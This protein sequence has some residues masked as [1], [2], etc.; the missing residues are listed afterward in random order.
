MLHEL[1]TNCVKYGALSVPEG[2]VTIN[3]VVRDRVLKLQWVERGGPEVI[4]P[5][6]RGFGTILIEQ[7]SN[8][9]GGSAQMLCEA[10]GVT[11]EVALPLPQ[12]I[13][14][15]A[16][17]DDFASKIVQAE[18]HKDSRTTR[19]SGS[20]LSGRSF[21]VI[22]DEPLIALDLAGSL[23]R[24]GAASVRSV[25]NEGEALEMIERT[26]FEGAL[27]DANLHGRSVDAIAAALARRKIPFVFVT[28]YGREALPS[29][30][31]HVTTLGK[32]F[33]HQQLLD[34]IKEVIPGG[35]VVRL[36]S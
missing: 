31:R 2:W 23:E 15:R 3:W 36:K 24:A 1:G 17:S 14:S 6:T 9:Q 35:N 5:N 33:S 4:A 8:S 19:T 29:A 34:A 18:T 25:G 16:P 12:S 28:G 11:W 20:I 32:P 30:F 21:L 13:A 27:L 10:E 7:S 26:D 22:E